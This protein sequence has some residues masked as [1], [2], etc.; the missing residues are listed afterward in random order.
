[1][2]KTAVVIAVVIIA[3]FSFNER[4]LYKKDIRN[5]L[6]IQGIGIDTKEDGTY[7][8][9][10]QALNTS[11]Q[12]ASISE[13]GNENPVKVYKVEGETV[14]TALKSVTEYEGK[15]PLYSQNRIIVIG[16]EAAEKGIEGIV[17]FF[18]RDVENSASL[19]IVT[20][21]GKAS[22]IL[23]TSSAKGEVAA[24]NIELS[25]RSAEYEAEIVELQLYELVNRYLDKN[26]SFAM[27][28]VALKKTGDEKRPEIKGTAV[29]K[30]GKLQNTL[31]ADETVML[32]FLLNDVYNGDI[33]YKSDKDENIA[34][35]I[36][37]SKTKRSV[38]LKNHTPIFNVRINVKC[39]IAEIYNGMTKS[40]SDERLREL[41]VD[42][43]KYLK[44]EIE[45]L[46][47]KLYVD[48]QSD[49]PGMSRLL[50]IFKP[51]FYRENEK[52]LNTIMADSQYNVEVNVTVRR[53]GHE[54][55]KIK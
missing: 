43:E 11:T 24:R 47:Q 25:V 51:S 33:A 44:A 34:I 8:V 46:V 49:V 16:R 31:S 48:M 1:M 32:N 7:S 50:Y 39:D 38:S 53:V 23:E 36:I 14:Y 37:N 13:G 26:G 54:F 4:E 5:R 3:L 29:F 42:A 35:S 15:I 2:R 40:V 45:K 28:V 19:R 17:D 18:V 10:V 55:V 12:S 27:P 6:V 52:N 9:T 41:Q 30:D 20:A 21:D 22:E